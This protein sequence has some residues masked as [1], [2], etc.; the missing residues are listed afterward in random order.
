MRGWDRQS[1]LL[2]LVLAACSPAKGL[3]DSPFGFWRT[4]KGQELYIN[5]DGTYRLC[6]L[7]MCDTG[8]TKAGGAKTI[9]LLGFNSLSAAKRLLIESGQQEAIRTNCQVFQMDF[10]SPR[11]GAPYY[12]LEKLACEAPYLDFGSMFFTAEKQGW[13]WKTTR[14]RGAP[15]YVF[16]EQGRE[17]FIFV[18]QKEY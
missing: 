6:D 3:S 5:R 1:L 8:K 16:G 12:D 17:A 15:C 2:L 11:P 4:D 14:C 9:S 13:L 7:G 10:P 18:K